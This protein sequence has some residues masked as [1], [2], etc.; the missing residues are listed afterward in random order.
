VRALAA[1]PAAKGIAAERSRPLRPTKLETLPGFWAPQ[2][3]K[4]F[5]PVFIWLQ[6]TCMIL[7]RHSLV[8]K[9]GAKVKKSFQQTKFFAKKILG[10]RKKNSWRNIK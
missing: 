10:K 7:Q 6:F 8:K 4:K 2:N 9:S 5:A 3:L 1:L